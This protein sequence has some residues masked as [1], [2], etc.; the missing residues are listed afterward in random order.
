MIKVRIV[1]DYDYAEFIEG[2][3]SEFLAIRQAKEKLIDI[4]YSS[5]AWYN[6]EDDFESIEYSALI[7][8]ETRGE[9]E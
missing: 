6:S 7:I 1:C 8:Y 5:A 2:I 9:N 3:E 4:K